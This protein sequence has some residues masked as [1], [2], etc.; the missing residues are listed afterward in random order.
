LVLQQGPRVLPTPQ[1]LKQCFEI[2]MEIGC[3]DVI[4]I[5]TAQDHI[6]W[7]ALVLVLLNL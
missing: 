4:W 1:E 6:Q 5:A 3:E 7:Q 2:N